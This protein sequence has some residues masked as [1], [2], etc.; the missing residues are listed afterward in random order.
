[1]NV[2]EKQ[3]MKEITH[4]IIIMIKTIVIIKP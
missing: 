2:K 1:V 4:T 3:I